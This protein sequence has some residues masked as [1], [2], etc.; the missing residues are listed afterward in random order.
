[1]EPKRTPQ[2]EHD[3]SLERR[4]TLRRLAKMLGLLLVVFIAVSQLH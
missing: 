3:W 2:S 1:M 4:E